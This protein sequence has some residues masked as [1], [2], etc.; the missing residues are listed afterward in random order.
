MS[1][2][3]PRNCA[4]FFWRNSL[5]TRVTVCRIQASVGVVLQKSKK[6]I[7]SH[8]IQLA[9]LQGLAGKLVGLP[10]HRRMQAQHFPG[11]RDAQDQSLAVSR[12][13]ESFTRP[14]QIMCTP[15]GAWPSTNSTAPCG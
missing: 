6:V 5:S 4:S 11:L 13:V 9:G 10:R 14:L 2:V 8:K 1:N 3:D 15:R 7:A 12:S